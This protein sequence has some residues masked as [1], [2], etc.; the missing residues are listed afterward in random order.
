MGYTLIETDQDNLGLILANGQVTFLHCEV[1]K[2]YYYVLQKGDNFGFHDLS[3]NAFWLTMA[4][5]HV[6]RYKHYIITRK[7]GIVRA[8]DGSNWHDGTCTTRK[9]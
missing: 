8:S 3:A 1:G 5:Q 2:S 7:A 4:T 9:N 6:K